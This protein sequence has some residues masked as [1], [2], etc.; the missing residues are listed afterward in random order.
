MHRSYKPGCVNGTT[1]GNAMFDYNY[2]S[3]KLMISV[4][5]LEEVNSILNLKSRVCSDSMIKISLNYIY[6]YKELTWRSPM[7]G[8]PIF[9]CHL[10]LHIKY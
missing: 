1:H 4:L 2:N 3:M 8:G 6:T 5:N 7:C 9:I 10:T